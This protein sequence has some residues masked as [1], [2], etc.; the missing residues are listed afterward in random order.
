MTPVFTLIGNSFETYFKKENLVYIVK[1]LLAQIL[2]GVGFAIPVVVLGFLF[3]GS[4]SFLETSDT[5]TFINRL[6]SLG[7][8]AVLFI[9]AATLVSSW[10]NASVL[11]AV[12]NIVNKRIKSVGETLSMGWKFVWKY[13]GISVLS[14]LIIFVGFLFFIIPAIVFGVWFSFALF[15]LVDKNTG[16]VESLSKSK[17]LVSGVF[18]PVLGRNILFGFLMVSIY[19]ALSFIPFVGSLLLTFF[20]PFHIVLSYL[21][22]EDLKRVKNK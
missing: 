4:M 3:A 20:T 15:S 17:S 1:I 16:V 9:F 12:S 7:P 21:L 6:L 14:G 10:L 2:I 5:G 22:Y 13:L 11:V 8:V 19:V 18:W